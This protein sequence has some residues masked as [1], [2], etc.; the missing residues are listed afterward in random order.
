MCIVI[1]MI[2]EQYRNQSLSY[3]EYLLC[4]AIDRTAKIEINAMENI[5]EILYLLGR[6]S[7]FKRSSAS[8][9]DARTTVRSQLVFKSKLKTHV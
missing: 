8:E 6:S 9:Y 7:S 2:T 1:I 4:Y 3:L 5:V